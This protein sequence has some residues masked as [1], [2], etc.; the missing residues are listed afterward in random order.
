MQPGS[1]PQGWVPVCIGESASGNSG[2]NSWS[3]RRPPET[4]CASVGGTGWSIERSHYRYAEPID[5]IDA[6]REQL[7]ESARIQH[8][9]ENWDADFQ[10][11]ASWCLDD[12]IGYA[13]ETAAGA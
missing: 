4:P 8:G 6:R 9:S 5:A 13:L 10:A 1:A 3:S 11:G 2:L 12:A 7:L